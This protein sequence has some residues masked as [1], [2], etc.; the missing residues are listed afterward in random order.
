MSKCKSE[1]VWYVCGCEVCKI[2]MYM[3]EIAVYVCVSK[4]TDKQIIMTRMVMKPFLMDN[5]YNLHVYMFH[6][7]DIDLLKSAMY[8]YT[9]TSMWRPI[10]YRR[11][12]NM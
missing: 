11:S 5:I 10:R 8:T 6:Q 12:G 1:Y 7:V 3:C 2:C 4:G 9:T